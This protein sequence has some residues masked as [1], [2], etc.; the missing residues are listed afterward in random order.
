MRFDVLRAHQAACAP[1]PAW[2]ADDL[3]HGPGERL[4]QPFRLHHA[5]EHLGGEALGCLPALHAFATGSLG[6][7]CARQDRRRAAAFA[8]CCRGTASLPA[9]QKVLCGMQLPPGCTPQQPSDRLPPFGCPAA[10]GVCR[11]MPHHG[12]ASA[13]RQLVHGGGPFSAAGLHRTFIHKAKGEASAHLVHAATHVLQSLPGSF[14]G[15]A[16]PSSRL[17]LLPTCTPTPRLRSGTRTTHATAPPPP[18][19]RAQVYVD[20][21]DAFR[22][23]SSH[24]QQ[25]TVLLSANLALFIVVMYRRVVP[26][27]LQAGLPH[28]APNSPC[29]SCTWRVGH[30]QT[31]CLLRLATAAP[32]WCAR[33]CRLV[34]TAIHTLLTPEGRAL[35]K[36]LLHEAAASVHGY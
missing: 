31:E 24:K 35:T 36:Q 8:A 20:S 16:R 9:E 27:Q 3:C 6:T 23:L 5:H 22:Q 32:A 7:S 28:P 21:M 18:Q 33:P 29:C 17:G 1:R 25:R 2:S 30:G 10:A 4:H 14:K 34:E 11:S 26:P 13:V 12:V 19:W 15:C